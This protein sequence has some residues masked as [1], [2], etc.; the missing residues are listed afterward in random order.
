MIVFVLSYYIFSFKSL[1]FLMRDIKGMDPYRRGVEE[2]L[3]GVQG[4]KTIITMY[5]MRKKIFFQ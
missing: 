3:G 2:E 5:Y 4:G 1:S